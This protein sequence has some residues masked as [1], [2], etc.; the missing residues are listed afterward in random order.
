MA[1]EVNLHFPSNISTIDPALAFDEVS[2]VAINQT[3]EP[4]FEY[5]YLKRPFTLKPL[6]AQTFP[7]IT[8]NGKTYT[9]KIKK[10]VLYQTDPSLPQKKRFV[11]AIDFINQFKRLALRSL[12]SPGRSFFSEVIVGF[13]QFEQK[14]NNNWENIFKNNIKGLSA[15]DDNTLIIKLTR[16]EP[17]LIN[18]LSLTFV[19]PLPEESIR[20]YQNNFNKNMIGTGP[21]VLSS[22][23]K[24]KKLSLVKN[25]N[26]RH[27]HYPHSGDRFSHTKGL[28]HDTNKVLPLTNKVNFHIINKEEEYWNMFIKGK[29]HWIEAPKTHSEQLR[30]NHTTLEKLFSEKGIEQ[31]LQANCSARWLAFNM[32]DPVLGQNKWLRRAIGH[33]I[34]YVKYIEIVTNNTAQRAN[35]VLFPGIPG[36][37]PSQS[38][39]KSFDLAKAKRFL[40][41]AGHPLGNN[42]PAFTYTTRGTSK[43]SM[44]EAQFFK[45]SL[46]KIG[47]N[48]IIEKS[49][50]SNLLKKGREGKL[51]VWTDGWIC[52]YPD[53]QNILQ[54]LIS[55]N[56]P[57]GVNK[58]SFSNRR[59]DELYKLLT[60]TSKARVKNT[61][62]AEIDEIIG[63]E[64]PWI[65]LYYNRSLI[66]KNSGLKNLRYSNFVRNYVK[67]LSLD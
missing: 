4:L 26:F 18:Y 41:K 12:K 60:N 37:N 8:N 31:R 39:G 34:N 63:E 57:P 48:I 65:M 49:S 1:E 2:L 9:I 21:Y 67:Y 14:I 22:W 13:K 50:F 23:E 10:N 52:D 32:T 59:V 7:K 28:L 3:Y 30:N 43:T 58:T 45:T 36:Y 47:I 5:H 20:F 16:P 55:S 35:S 24:G 27:E 51:Q 17:Q 42:L 54:L 53:P 62:I 40:V 38:I 29:L 15:P 46:K 66:L 64:S 6:L 44:E 25:Y 11:K 19:V 61:Y 56:H 33:A